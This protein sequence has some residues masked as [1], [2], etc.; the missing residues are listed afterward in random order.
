MTRPSERE[1]RNE[2]ESLDETDDDMALSDVCC[3]WKDDCEHDEHVIVV[4]FTD[5]DT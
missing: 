4:D 3:S 2:V 1:L 5:T